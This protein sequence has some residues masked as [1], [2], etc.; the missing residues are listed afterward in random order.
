M[1]ISEEYR[2]LNAQLHENPDY[3][4]S[5]RQWADHIKALSTKLGTRDILDYGCGKRTLQTAL[6]CEI[7]NYDPCIPE[8]S[9]PPE[10]ALIVVCGDVLEHIEPENLDDVLDDLKRVVKHVGFFVIHTGPAKKH[11]ADGRNAH[12]IQEGWEWWR[13]KLESRF[14]IFGQEEHGKNLVVVVGCLSS[15]TA[16]AS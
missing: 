12:L 2:K 9:S 6:G 16:K 4:V 13:P 5:G 8:F 11:L 1:L 3:G 10:P 15:G 7:K 14:K